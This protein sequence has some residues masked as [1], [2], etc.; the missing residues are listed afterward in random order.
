MLSNS[1]PRDR[2]GVYMGV[3]NMFIVI[4]MLIQ[5]VSLPFFYN[6]ILG[7]NP[8]NVIRLA[9]ALLA[10]GAVA[11]AFVKVPESE[12]GASGPVSAGGQ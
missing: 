3:F 1:I 8:A 12:G 6:P 9:G 2:V 10:C 5:N 4:P 11:C 7:G